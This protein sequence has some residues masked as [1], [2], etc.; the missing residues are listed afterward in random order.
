MTL[1]IGLDL[2]DRVGLLLLPGIA[3]ELEEERHKSMMLL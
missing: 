3:D 1:L 2:R